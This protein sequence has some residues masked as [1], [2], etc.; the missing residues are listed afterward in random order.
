MQPRSKTATEALY[1]K[2]TRFQIKGERGRVGEHCYA[3]TPPWD[4]LAFPLKKFFACQV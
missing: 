3:R 4:N 2:S 1:T